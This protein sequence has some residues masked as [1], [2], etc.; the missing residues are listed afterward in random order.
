MADPNAA[1][2][3]QPGQPAL[4]ALSPNPLL[5]ESLG[6][7]TLVEYSEEDQRVGIRFECLER[8][9]HSDGRIAQ[10]GFVTAWMDAAM[11]HAVMLS[12]NKR[13]NVASL[14]INVRFLRA[15]GPGAVIAR[16]WVVRMGRRV[17]FLEGSLEDTSGQRLATATSS[18]M[19]VPLQT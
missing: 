7:A 16:G 1:P 9:C 12:S 14:D 19:L 17:A 11:A 10:G 15:A 5:W 18:G 6:G 2:S 13:Y 4:P 3:D 8:F